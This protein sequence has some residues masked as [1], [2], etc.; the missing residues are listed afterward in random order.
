MEVLAR[1]PSQS[2]HVYSECICLH[3][4]SAQSAAA[5]RLHGMRAPARSA[6]RDQAGGLH[7]ADSPLDGGEQCAKLVA[8][9]LN[10]MRDNAAQIWAHANSSHWSWTH[11]RRTQGVERGGLHAANAALNEREQGAVAVAQLPNHARRPALGQVPVA[12]RL[13][14]QHGLRGVDRVQR[15]QRRGCDQGYSCACQARMSCSKPDCA[16]QPCWVLA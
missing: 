14:Q 3:A 12:G 6:Q 13:L 5:K 16:C 11:A 4:S 15:A 2:I 9:L 10:D 7:A 8:Q 1:A